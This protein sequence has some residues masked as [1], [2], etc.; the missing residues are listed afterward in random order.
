MRVL[1]MDIDVQQLRRDA[2]CGQVSVEQ[3]LEVIDK[4]QRTL[5]GL[6]RENQ[7]LLDRLAQ[8]EPERC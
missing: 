1:P 2:H 3:L 4:Q 7:R 6:R 5:Q 8:Y